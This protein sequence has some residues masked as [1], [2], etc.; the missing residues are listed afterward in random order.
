M[1]RYYKITLET[2][3]ASQEEVSKVMVEKLGWRKTDCDIFEDG[4]VTFGAE[5]ELCGGQSEDEAYE[6]MKYKFKEILGRDVKFSIRMYYL[7]EVPYN[8]YG[9]I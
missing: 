9:E 2:K 5:G 3:E 6:E 1:S 7:E 4:I 8:D